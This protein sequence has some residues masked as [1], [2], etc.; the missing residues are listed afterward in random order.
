MTHCHTQNPCFVRYTVIATHKDL[1]RIVP[2]SLSHAKTSYSSSQSQ[3][4]T[5]RPPIHCPRVNVTHKDLTRIV[6]H[7]A[8]SLC[9]DLAQRCSL[10]SKVFVRDMTALCTKQSLCTKTRRC[11]TLHKDEALS[12]FAQRRGAVKLCTKTMLCAKS[13]QDAVVEHPSA[14]PIS[15]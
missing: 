6:A 9:K 12:N 1:T 5:Q 13:L 15:L 10:Q 7:R 14:V 11:Q 2:E 8:R 3:C 4:H